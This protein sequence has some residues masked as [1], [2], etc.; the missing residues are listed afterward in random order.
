M[1]D[2]NFDRTLIWPDV[3]FER[4]NQGGR[5]SA[6]SARFKLIQTHSGVNSPVERAELAPLRSHADRMFFQHDD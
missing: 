4:E 6:G 1:S 3:P 5:I 2:S